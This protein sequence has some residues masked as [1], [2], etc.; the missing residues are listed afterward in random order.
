MADENEPHRPIAEVRDA[1][2]ADTHQVLKSDPTNEDARLDIAL[3]ETFPTSDPPGLTPL[4]SGEPAPSSGFD[5][6]AE[7]KHLQQRE[8]AYSLWERD[9]RPEGRHDDHWHA[10]AE[11]APEAGT[12]P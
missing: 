2:D 9:G 11:E 4:G 1:H 7:R 8:R 6:E 3:D 5:E 10:A 12:A